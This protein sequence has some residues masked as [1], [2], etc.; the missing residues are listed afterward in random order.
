MK[1]AIFFLILSMAMAIYSLKSHYGTSGL[2]WRIS[3]YLFPLLIAVFISVISIFLFLEGIRDIKSLDK[4]KIEKDNKMKWKD[5][6]F[7]IL[8]SISYYI[9]MGLIGFI[10]STLIFLMSLFVYLGERRIWLITLISILST[11]SI[12][13]IFGVLL[14][15]MLP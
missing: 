2:Q 6:L 4:N 9:T 14:N 5:V 15:V 8:V 1:E 7:T 12:Y 3:P 13:I 11:A 10:A